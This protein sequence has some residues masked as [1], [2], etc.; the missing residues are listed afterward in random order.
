MTVWDRG[1]GGT[2]GEARGCPRD[3]GHGVN[4]RMPRLSLLSS[5]Q[6]PGAGWGPRA[7]KGLVLHSWGQ[8]SRS[9]PFGTRVGCHR[10][11]NCDFVSPTCPF[12]SRLPFS[13]SLPWRVLCAGHRELLCLRLLVREPHRGLEGGRRPSTGYS[14]PCPLPSRPFFVSWSCHDEVT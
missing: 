7:S 11:D 3:D 5:A 4:A 8:K 14:C 13:C 6:R 12:R 10:D 2:G 1:P 9:C